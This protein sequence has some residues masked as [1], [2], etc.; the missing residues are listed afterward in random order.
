MA[1]KGGS[2]VMDDG[3]KVL[4]SGTDQTVEPKSKVKKE[5]VNAKPSG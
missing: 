1:N 5:K 4:V 2:Y 3:K